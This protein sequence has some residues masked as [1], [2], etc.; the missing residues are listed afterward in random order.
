MT[1][2]CINRICTCQKII[3]TDLGIKFNTTVSLSP[4]SF[5]CFYLLLNTNRLCQCSSDVTFSLS[6]SLFSKSF[7]KDTTKLHKTGEHLTNPI[8]FSGFEH[9]LTTLLFIVKSDLVV[10]TL[11][12]FSVSS[13]FFHRLEFFI[14]PFVFRTTTCLHALD[15]PVAV[16]THPVNTRCT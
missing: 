10:L 3:N 4:S 15:K 14:T 13:V 12:P 5:C 1:L 16:F 6:V 9:C 7:R 8:S 11:N 2:D